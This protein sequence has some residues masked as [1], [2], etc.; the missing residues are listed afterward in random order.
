[1]NRQC[2][3]KTEEEDRRHAQ[4]AVQADPNKRRVFGVRRSSAALIVCRSSRRLFGPL[5]LD[6][7]RQGT[8]IKTKMLRFVSGYHHCPVRSWLHAHPQMRM[9]PGSPVPLTTQL[10]GLSDAE[11]FRP[12]GLFRLR[13]IANKSRPTMRV[14]RSRS[15]GRADP[16]SLGGINRRTAIQHKSIARPTRYPRSIP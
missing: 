8:A 11:A 15:T 12:N 9:K 14:Q 7:G 4:Q 10:M 13:T 16:W 2:R 6:V 1:M 5:N 3:K